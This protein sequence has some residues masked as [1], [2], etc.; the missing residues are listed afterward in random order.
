MIT[1]EKPFNNPKAKGDITG[2]FEILIP[3]ELWEKIVKAQAKHPKLTFSWITRYALF[4]MITQKSFWKIAKF[5]ILLKK[6]KAYSKSREVCHR[7]LIC[8]YNDDQK[9]LKIIAAE[10]Q[11]P[12]SVLVRIALFWYL[13][14]F[15]ADEIPDFDQAESK[16]EMFKKLSFEKIKKYGTKFVKSLEIIRLEE[17]YVSAWTLSRSSIF[18]SNEL[19]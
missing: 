18:L 19:W 11:R 12:I 4:T 9:R 2:V 5:A 8:L 7:H 13:H 17:S 6:D 10:L 3:N 1:N 15:N 14:E 16:D